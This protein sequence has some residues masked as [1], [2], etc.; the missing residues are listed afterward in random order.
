MKN[1]VL[2]SYLIIFLIFTFSYQIFAQ[3][4]EFQ[5]PSSLPTSYGVFGISVVDENVVWAVAFDRSLGNDVP[6]D[7]IT[8]IL[9]TTDGGVNWEVIDVQEA[10]GRIS[11]DIVATND[12]TAFITT[13]D[14]NNGSGRG[15]FKTTDGGSTWTEIYSQSS[16]GVWIRFF[17]ENDG[18]I[19]NREL[20]STTDDGGAT[21]ETV[22]NSSIPSFEND[23]FTIVI[24]GTSSCNVIDNHIWFG[25][26]NG[27]IFKSINKGKDWEVMN[28]NLSSFGNISSIAFK[29]TMNGLMA[30]REGASP[31]YTYARTMDGGET[32]VDLTPNFSLGVDLI[33]YVPGSDGLFIGTTSQNIGGSKKT[34]YSNNFGETWTEI[35]DTNIEYGPT[36]FLSQEVGWSSRGRQAVNGQSVMLKWKGSDLIS[37]STKEIISSSKVTLIPNPVSDFLTIEIGEQLGGDHLNFEIISL[38]GRVAKTWKSIVIEKININLRDLSKGFYVLKIEGK[39]KIISKKI[40]KE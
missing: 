1:L 21:W 40:I 13:Q 27:R 12:S 3:A 9:R 6:T 2:K 8:K 24:N 22:P 37:T 5:A 29:D 23:E 18:V 11:F 38:D 16:G 7:H 19:I 30:G 39:D 4:W 17:N 25:T 26:S 10:E 31:S 20:I 15:V 34:V 14:Y 36:Q 28:T 35:D 32:W 33:S